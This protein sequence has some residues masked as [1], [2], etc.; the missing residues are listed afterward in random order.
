MTQSAPSP[1]ALL[2]RCSGSSQDLDSGKNS[3][4]N[5]LFSKKGSW[6]RTRK[7][8]SLG[9]GRQ[10][11]S[12]RSPLQNCYIIQQNELLREKS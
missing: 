12:R 3:A 1:A 5:E 6:S 7:D 4:R 2:T 9:H 10:A 11:W 8:M